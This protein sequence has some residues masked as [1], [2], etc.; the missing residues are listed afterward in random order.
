MAVNIGPRIGIDGEKE[1]RAQINNIIQQAKTLDSEM[2]AVAASFTSSTSAEEK[3]AKT[4]GIH[5]QQLKVQQDRVA[6]LKEGL[7]KAAKEFGEADTRTLKWKQAV[8]EATAE[9]N[10]MENELDESADATGDMGEALENT[11]DKAISFAEVLKGSLVAQAVV[12]GVKKLADGMKSLA[13]D[14]VSTGMGFESQMS[15]VQAISGATA[16]DMERLNQKAKEMGA[17]TKFSATES[18]EAL[19]YM[20]MAGWKTEDMLSGLKGV[21]NLAAA[22][23]EDLAATSDII[24][25][26]MT[27][28]GMNASEAEH[29]AD[30]L[31]VAS[32]N[33]NTNVGMMGE[34]FK[35]VAPIAGTLGY[36]VEDTAIAIGLMA[37]N[38][39]KASQAGT[40]LRSII[41]RLSTDAGA[42]SKSLGALGTLTDALGVQF[43]NLDG[44][45][46]NLSDVL[47]DARKAWSGL[48]QEQQTS[49]AKTIAGQEAMSGWL[50]IMNASE[51]DVN[52]LAA[53]I[54]SADGAAEKMAGTMN[55]NLAGAITI[56]KS[57]F[58]SIGISVYERFQEPMRKAAEMV[59]EKVI[60][61]IQSFVDSGGVEKVARGFQALAPAIAAATTAFAAYKVAASITG[62]ID[63]VKKSV[64]ALNMA[65]SANPIMAIITLIAAV[66]AA[67]VTLYMTNEDFRNKVNA[68]WEG[69]KTTVSGVV[70]ALVVFF[71]QTVPNGIRSLVLAFENMWS[72]ITRTVGNIK[73]AIITGIGAAVDWIKSLPS[74]AW[75][76]GK[77]MISG[78]V[79][80][81]KSKASSMVDAVK[82]VGKG[83]RSNLHFSRPDEGPLRDY[84]TW[85][86][87]FM[88]GLAAGIRAN[89][90]RVQDAVANLASGMELPPIQTSISALQPATAAA[91]ARGFGGGITLNIYGAPGQDVNQMADIVMSRIESV[92]RRK[93]LVFG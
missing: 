71:T 37:N 43:Y 39:I 16:E 30:V 50:A 86:P 45:T 46:R 78:F 76:W 8:N 17:T 26:A 89:T 55:S 73:T 10:R 57:G 62:T 67:L 88:E 6:A 74:Q 72:A 19:E 3:A 85:M 7:A 28:F 38:G 79:D 69:I 33:A 58:E 15:R 54:T 11:K 56:M 13:K 4:A 35:Y 41:T 61:A 44:S 77:D 66:G 82:N 93:E 23:G 27:A 40:S 34:T 42:S 70:N 29:F 91:G 65:I 1:F 32:S 47:M 63:A 84:E 18:G 9:L 14:I 5:A 2:K 60:P 12:S 59:T 31:A 25:D 52:S 83:I 87:D 64:I 24:T 68:I 53:S 20:A 21:M 92:T 48:S 81:I 90:W 36:N 75:N 22:S 80:G 49:Y 51:E